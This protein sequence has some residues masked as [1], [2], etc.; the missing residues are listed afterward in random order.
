MNAD[1]VQH[2]RALVDERRRLEVAAY[3]AWRASFD[4]DS[5]QRHELWAA[6]VISRSALDRAIFQLKHE[7]ADRER[8]AAEGKAL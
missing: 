2:F 6:W 5:D 4:V 3:T 8:I 7:V 1:T